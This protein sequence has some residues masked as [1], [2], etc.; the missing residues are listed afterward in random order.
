VE[1]ALGADPVL[2]IGVVQFA[3]QLLEARQAEHEAVKQG[4][5][6]AG[7]RDLRIQAPVL[8]VGGMAAQVKA[9]V[10]PG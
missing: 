3:V 6:D 1:G 8:H 7:G 9:L 2:E 5:E 10:E 4:Q